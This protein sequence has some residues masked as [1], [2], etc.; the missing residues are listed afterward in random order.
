MWNSVDNPDIENV[1]ISKI[2][3]SVFLKV[4]RH[5]MEGGAATFASSVSIPFSY[6]QRPEPIKINVNRTFRY[7]VVYND[8][9]VIFDGV[10]NG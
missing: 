2:A 4:N 3:H 5:G 7:Q 10:Y 8:S 1:Y 6:C 9:S